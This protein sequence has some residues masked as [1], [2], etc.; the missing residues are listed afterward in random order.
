MNTLPSP[1]KMIVFA[2]IATVSLSLAGIALADR[3]DQAPGSI[4]AK[5]PGQS[6]GSPDAT[7][8]AP[9]QT[10]PPVDEEALKEGVQ[11]TELGTSRIL[12]VL[13]PDAADVDKIAKQRFSDVHF[14]VFPSSIQLTEDEIAPKALH[15]MGNDRYADL[16]VHVQTSS[17]LRNRLGT[18]ELHEGQSTVTV[19]DPQ[20]EEIKVIHTARNDGERLADS[21]E[22]ERSAREAS[23]D[24]AVTEAIT[25]L[26]EVAHK[27]MLYEAEFAP[28]KDH[29]HLLRILRY[30]EEME[31]VYH[32]RQMKFDK[33]SGRALVEIIAKP[34]TETLWRAHLEQ[35]PDANEKERGRKKPLRFKANREMRESFPDWFKH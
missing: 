9:F 35:W 23:A 32:T 4:E 2:F 24:A 14:R 26:L 17:R 12:L 31:G 28:V 8:K 11:I 10:P 21:F 29:S 20:S 34:G 15:E 19:Y 3:S 30:I 16:V 5:S 7:G 6:N 1:P 25:K 13:S 33:E 22:A 27:S 18:L